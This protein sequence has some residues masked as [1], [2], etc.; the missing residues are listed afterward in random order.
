MAANN[1]SPIMVELQGGFKNHSAHI[2]AHFLDLEH[3]Q[4]HSR[5]SAASDLA[6]ERISFSSAL[7]C[8]FTCLILIVPFILPCGGCHNNELSSPPINSVLETGGN[9]IQI[10]RLNHRKSNSNQ[11]LSGYN[12]ES[13]LKRNMTLLPARRWSSLLLLP[14]CSILSRLD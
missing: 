2:I 3:L 13:K 14:C 11:L 7:S 5:K 12:L 9:S 8:F 4:F 6:S 1:H 10:N